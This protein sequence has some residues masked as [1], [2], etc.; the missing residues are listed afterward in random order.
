MKKI[1][2]FFSLFLFASNVMAQIYT[3]EF[4]G[5]VYSAGGA[6]AWRPEPLRDIVGQNFTGRF[7]YDDAVV[8]IIENPDTIYTRYYYNQNTSVEISLD[9]LSITYLNKPVEIIVDN[10]HYEPRPRQYYDFFSYSFTTNISDF[11]PAKYQIYFL[12]TTGTVFNSFAL[13]TSF[14]VSDFETNVFNIYMGT[15]EHPIHFYGQIINVELIPEPTALVFLTLG[16]L[17]LRRK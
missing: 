3:F 5:H 6:L 12:D 13:P 11:G 7:R 8:P 1:I 4:T 9:E 2:L 16:T 14:N 10:N 15:D 17:L